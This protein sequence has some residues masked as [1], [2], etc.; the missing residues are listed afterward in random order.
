MGWCLPMWQVS[1]W[2]GYCLVIRSTSVLSFCFCV[3]CRQVNFRSNF[4]EYVGVP[5]IPL[6]F[7]PGYRMWLLQD[8]CP[9]CCESQLMSPPLIL[10]SPP[11]HRDGWHLKDVPSPPMSAADFHSF[12]WPSVFVPCL[13]HTC[14][15]YPHP[16][17][18]PLSTQFLISICFL[19]LFYSP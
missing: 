2:A 9:H 11:I 16:H 5:I 6:W 17:L 12:L 19:W 13:F 10:G 8:V 7:D 1:S 18:S 3:S 15:W 14:S 4:C